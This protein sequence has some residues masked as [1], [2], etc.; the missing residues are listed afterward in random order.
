VPIIVYAD[1]LAVHLPQKYF[2]TGIVRIEAQIRIGGDLSRR[3]PLRRRGR[4]EIG[5][6]VTDPAREIVKKKVS[7][8]C[9]F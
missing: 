4:I 9:C 8:H 3:G 7:F 2:F 1:E 6:P 5:F